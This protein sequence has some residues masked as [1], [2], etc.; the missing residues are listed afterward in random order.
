[1]QQGW[2]IGEE[3]EDWGL[4]SV[5]WTRARH[6][7]LGGP[8]LWPWLWRPKAIGSA[9]FLLRVSVVGIALEMDLPKLSSIVA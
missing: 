6:S 1:M 7:F 8:L 5:Q 9:C 4:P 3:N 2:E